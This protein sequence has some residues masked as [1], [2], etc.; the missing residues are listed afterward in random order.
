[1]KEKYEDNEKLLFKTSVIPSGGLRATIYSEI[2][3]I[4]DNKIQYSLNIDKNL[5]TI[6]FIEMDTD[7]IIDICKIIGIFI[8]NAIDEVQYL[9]EKNILISIFLE[10]DFLCIKVSNNYGRII[11]IN[12]I[13]DEGYTTK[14]KG[15]GYGLFLVKKIIEKNKNFEIKTEISK[16]YFSQT[17]FIKHKK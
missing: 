14:G 15:H 16:N 11:D 9:K 6:D 7:S 12:K 5:K 10:G 1:M 4:I 3:K 2:L 8:D 17:L 13:F